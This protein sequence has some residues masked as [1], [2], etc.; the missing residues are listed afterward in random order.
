MSDHYQT[1]RITHPDHPGW[2]FLVKHHYDDM[3]APWEEHDCHGEVTK[4]DA[5][6]HPHRHGTGKAAGEVVIYEAACT[7]WCYDYAGAMKIAKRDGWGL[8]A[9]GLEAL[10][11]ELAYRQV[12]RGPFDNYKACV[13][14]AVELAATITP[15]PGQIRRDAVDADMERMR[16]WIA[17]DWHWCWIRVEACEAPGGIDADDLDW[18]SLGGLESDGEDYILEC[19]RGLADQIAGPAMEAKAAA[20]AAKVVADAE[21]AA[22]R[23]D[24][25]RYRKLRAMHWSDNR[26]TVVAHPRD[27]VKLGA[28]TFSGDLLDAALDA[29]TRYDYPSGAAG[30]QPEGETT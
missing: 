23:L 30:L 16:G 4:R 18:Q 11:L 1:T 28:M 15:T 22:L 24:A 14:R 2:T 13:A 17:N 6:R 29:D 3:A 10:K 27:S 7:V 21:L 25:A 19:A 8:D 12:H 9:K 26:L 5:S 20:D